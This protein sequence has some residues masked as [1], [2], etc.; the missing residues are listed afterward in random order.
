MRPLHITLPCDGK[1]VYYPSNGARGFSY[2]VLHPLGTP[3]G[4]QREFER[5]H[6]R[7]AVDVPYTIR[8]FGRTILPTPKG[9]DSIVHPIVYVDTASY[10]KELTIGDETDPILVPEVIITQSGLNEP[11]NYSVRTEWE[12]E[13]TLEDDPEHAIGFKKVSVKIAK[14][15][16]FVFTWGDNGDA[17]YS[18]IDTEAKLYGNKDPLYEKDFDFRGSKWEPPHLWPGVSIQHS[19]SIAVEAINHHPLSMFDFKA[20]Y[21]LPLVYIGAGLC[22]FY[23]KRT[24]LAYD[25]DMEIH[26]FFGGASGRTLVVSDNLFNVYIP[27]I[28]HLGLSSGSAIII[29]GGG[30]RDLF[31]YTFDPKVADQPRDEVLSLSHEWFNFGLLPIP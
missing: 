9:Y 26:I 3:G 14:D 21:I 2:V 13:Y 12:A 23:L 20:T 15:R 1:R 28:D 5:V 27:R 24:D 22:Y 11:P 6:D 17:K 10:L 25:T 16:N 7:V 30:E 31:K 4:V 29:K 8:P 18:I 19:M